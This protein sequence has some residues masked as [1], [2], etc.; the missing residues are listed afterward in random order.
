MLSLRSV[1]DLLVLVARET[2]G[3]VTRARGRGGRRLHA[4]LVTALPDLHTDE[5]YAADLADLERT[6]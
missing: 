3:L 6:S 2:G 5:P 1:A 4:A